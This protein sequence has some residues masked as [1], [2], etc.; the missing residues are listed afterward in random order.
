MT[1]APQDDEGNI[2]VDQILNDLAINPPL[3]EPLYYMT[4]DDELVEIET[5]DDPA[6]QFRGKQGGIRAYFDM[7]T[8][9]EAYM[10][11]EIQEVDMRPV[12]P[13]EAVVNRVQLAEL[14]DYAAADIETYGDTI[15][16]EVR[17]AV[18]DLQEVLRD[19][20]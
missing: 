20:A 10:D 6:T 7:D 14:I 1:T 13:G 18:D 11:G 3:R 17:D 4:T 9:Y 5:C 12:R 15:P 8:F 2:D 16:E 19:H